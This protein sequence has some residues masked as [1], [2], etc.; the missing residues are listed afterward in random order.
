[1]NIDSVLCQQ[2]VIL[3]PAYGRDYKTE[4]EVAKAYHSGVDFKIVGGPYCSVR[5]FP[6]VYVTI[7]FDR[8]RKTTSVF[9]DK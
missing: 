3:V 5:N 1:M 2:N 8:L 6:D 9:G 7:R 4:E